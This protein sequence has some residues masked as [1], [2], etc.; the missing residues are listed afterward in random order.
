M[1][2]H[3][4]LFALLFG[5]LVAARGHSQDLAAARQQAREG[6]A[7]AAIA[8]LRTVIAG[9]PESAPA[10][11]LLCEV[12]GSIDHLD[13]AIHECEAAANAAPKSSE[14]ALRLALAYGS[15]AEHSGTL[16]GMRMVGKIRASFEKAVHLDERSV[17]A[18]SDL[19]E[20]YVEAPTVVGGGLDKARALLPRLQ[21][22]SPERAH[23][24]AGMIAIKANDYATAEAELK[25]ALAVS[26]A[27]EAYVDLA[28]FERRR[29]QFPAA[30]AYARTAIER[31]G[32]HGADSVDA[33]RLLLQMNR[34]VPFAQDTLRRYLAAPHTSAVTPL[35]RV[36]TWLGE[37]LAA[38]GNKPEADAQFAAALAL[39]HD[40]APARKALGR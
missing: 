14:V 35:A 8:S 17:D 30:A 13:E 4:L 20:F 25:S 28:N 15:K 3:R 34:E 38:S 12:Y 32:A 11:A 37:S 16:T 6:K 10:H 26:H 22:V 9:G 7:D 19:G 2:R 33:A 40:Y 1:R 39:A 27:P 21:A 36:H 29:N 23:R 5:G 24:M 31:D 18:L